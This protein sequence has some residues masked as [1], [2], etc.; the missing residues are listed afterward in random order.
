LEGEEVEREIVEGGA[1]F[2]GTD[3]QDESFAELQAVDAE[4]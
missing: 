3:C 1:P 4:G 2:I